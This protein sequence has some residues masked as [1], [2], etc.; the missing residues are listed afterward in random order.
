MGTKIEG[1]SAPQAASTDRRRALLAELVGTYILVFIG[2][3][4]VL[5]ASTIPQV[6][7]LEAL[8]LIAAAFGCT[9]AGIIILL[10]RHSGAHINPAIT[11]ATTVAGMARRSEFL[12]YIGFQL[13][14]GLLAGLTLKLVFTA[15]ASSMELGST[16]L[17]PGI[18]PI[19]GVAIEVTGTFVL[20][21][22]A[23]S[24]SSFISSTT[25][26]GLLVGLTLFVLIMFI[27]PLTGASFNPARSL[28][29]S[30]FSGYFAGQLVY[31]VG[32]LIGGSL[33][34][35]LF[36]LWRSRHG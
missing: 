2:P 6:S 29:P 32:P 22:S 13:A 18:T 21:I 15:F 14:G 5:L 16:R 7:P 31:W 36:G 30:L 26:Q 35:L 1:P 33:A 4:S 11:L 10:G 24:A 34:G 28:G 27:G 12:P 19:E 20:A 23:L 3:S 25:K 8:T 17:A 9:V